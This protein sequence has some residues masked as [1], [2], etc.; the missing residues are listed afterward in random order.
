MRSPEYLPATRLLL[1]QLRSVRA[2]I[3]PRAVAGDRGLSQ[4]N[5]FYAHNHYIRH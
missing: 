1:T 5:H 3:A 4:Q 2:G